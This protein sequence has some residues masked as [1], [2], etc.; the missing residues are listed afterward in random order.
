MRRLKQPAILM[1]KT[2]NDGTP[3]YLT[4]MFE[5]TRNIHSHNLRGFSDNVFVPGPNSESGKRSFKYRG[6]VLWNSLP[7]DIKSLTTLSSFRKS[8]NNNNNNIFIE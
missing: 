8:L 2:L 6:A 4:K 1:Y 7:D 5:N 3:N